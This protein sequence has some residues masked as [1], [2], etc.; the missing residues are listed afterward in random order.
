MLRLLLVTLAFIVPALP[1]AAEIRQMA[2]KPGVSELRGACSK[3]GGQFDVSPDG[4]GYA[5]TTKDCDGKGGNC[6]VACDNNNNC[7]G[8]TPARI[9][10]PTT[11]IGILQ[12]GDMVLRD[13][14]VTGST[15]SLSSPSTGGTKPPSDDSNPWPDGPI[16]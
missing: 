4:Q 13:P 11:L 14:V 8:S 1:A 10:K 6:T 15:N 7:T 2:A 3:A 16:F 12:N 9:V 5:C